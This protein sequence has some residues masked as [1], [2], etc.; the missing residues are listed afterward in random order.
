MCGKCSAF[1]WPKRKKQICRL[2]NPFAAVFHYIKSSSW[3]N[4]CL[5]AIPISIECSVYCVYSVHISYLNMYHNV[6]TTDRTISHSTRQ[7]WRLDASFHIRAA[8]GQGCLGSFLISQQGFIYMILYDFI[9]PWTWNPTKRENNEQHPRDS[10]L[11]AMR[12]TSRAASRPSPVGTSTPWRKN[13]AKSVPR[14]TS[15]MYCIMV[16]I[17]IIWHIRYGCVMS[18]AV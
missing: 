2:N 17:N 9:V 1:T 12:S 11:E 4:H 8:I 3:A 14:Y 15:H 18:R 7:L 5:L 13:D 10:W 16:H 6:Q